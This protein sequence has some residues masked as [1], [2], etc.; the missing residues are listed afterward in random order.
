MRKPGH[1]R[2]EEPNSVRISRLSALTGKLP[3]LA[4]KSCQ[5]PSSN[6]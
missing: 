1:W 3:R 4:G 5:I 6:R 2:C